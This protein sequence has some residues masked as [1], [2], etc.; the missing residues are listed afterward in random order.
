MTLGTLSSEKLRNLEEL[1]LLPK[2]ATA[3]MIQEK[4]QSDLASSKNNSPKIGAEHQGLPWFDTL[5]EGSRLGNMKM[6]MGSTQRRDGT[7]QVKWEIA[8][9]TA[10]GEDEAPQTPSTNTK[11]KLGDVVDEDSK[12]EEPN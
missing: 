7:V 11:R 3:D 5:V 2:E 4:T 10:E 1:G 8:E 6:S 12:M 9:W